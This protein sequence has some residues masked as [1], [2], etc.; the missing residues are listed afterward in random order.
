M[1]EV[2][3]LAMHGFVPFDLSIP[4][5]VFGQLRLPGRQ[6]GYRVRVCGEEKEVRTGAFS[7]CAPSG[8]RRLASADTVIIPGVEDPALPVRPAVLAAIRAAWKNGARI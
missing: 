1:H 4:C 2:A 3:V 5:G 6:P 8:L 7:L